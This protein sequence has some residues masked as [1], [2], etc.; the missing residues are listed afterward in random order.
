VNAA[1]IATARHRLAATALAAALGARASVTRAAEPAADPAQER[2]VVAAPS[3]APP[4][5][6]ERPLGAALAIGA[7]YGGT[8]RGG[9]F[10]DG[11]GV[12]LAV[13][14]P[15]WYD[16]PELW[17]ELRYVFPRAFDAPSNVVETFAGRAGVSMRWLEHLRVGIG[18]GVDRESL[19][20]TTVANMGP[21]GP[22]STTTVAPNWQ[23]AARAFARVVSRSWR[24]FSLS[25]T[26]LLDAVHSPDPVNTLRPGLTVEGWWRS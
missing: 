19:S 11:P 22:T 12:S 14:E 4:P 8:I 2:P 10:W 25:A 3:P 24:G 9:A 26:L 1:R 6:A 16:D 15:S 13:D 5:T 7:T 23:P 21:G 20:F 17:M 18:V